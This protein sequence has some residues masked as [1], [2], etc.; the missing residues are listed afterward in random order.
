M[1]IWKYLCL[2]VTAEIH[3]Y[4]ATAFQF[5]IGIFILAN[6]VRSATFSGFWLTFVWI[7]LTKFSAFQVMSWATVSSFLHVAFIFDFRFFKDWKSRSNKL[8]FS[9]VTDKDDETI[10]K[11]SKVFVFSMSCFILYDYFG[12]I[13]GFVPI[14]T[15]GVFAQHFG[16]PELI[17]EGLRREKIVWIF[18]ERVL[19]PLNEKT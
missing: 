3:V 15:K 4:Q 18:Y 13:F 19:N 12:Y 16:G 8:I 2:Q 10:I 7:E 9:S 14:M 1:K 11:G 17:R 5:A 6:L